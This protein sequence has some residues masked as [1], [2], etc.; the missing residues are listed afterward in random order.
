MYVAPPAPAPSG[1]K[2]TIMTDR[3]GAYGPFTTPELRRI[4]AGWLAVEVQRAD[5]RTPAHIANILRAQRPLVLLWRDSE[6]FGHFI[7]LHARTA[8]N[9]RRCVELFDPIGFQSMGG[10]DPWAMYADDPL[11]LNGGGLRATLQAFESHGVPVH[12]NGNHGPQ[13]FDANSCGLWCLVRAAAPTAEPD[14]F[15]RH[16]IT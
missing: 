10:A 11:Q 12:Y 8:R 14:D 1:N 16:M 6:N 5:N 2:V 9:G 15:A 7:L 3:L 4:A 13:H